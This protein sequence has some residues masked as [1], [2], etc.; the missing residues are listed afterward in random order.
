MAEILPHIVWYANKQGR[1]IYSNQKWKKYSGVRDTWI[2][3]IHKEDIAQFFSVW[4]QC[5]DTHR[6]LCVEVRLKSAQG[7]YEWF[8]AQAE[9]LP[10]MKLQLSPNVCIFAILTSC[11][12]YAQRCEEGVWTGSLLNI[13]SGKQAYHQVV[14]ELGGRLEDV[15]TKCTE[16]IK[17]AVDPIVITNAVRSQRCPGRTVTLL[18]G[19]GDHFFQ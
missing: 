14:D 17:T 18:L 7:K 4:S 10:S 6:A 9:Y 1:V 12:L 5:I 8:A 19:R 16:I 2:H 11:Q 15:E 3:H 13:N